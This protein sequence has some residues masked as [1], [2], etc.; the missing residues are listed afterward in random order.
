MI[1]AIKLQV[2]FRLYMHILVMTRIVP[3]HSLGGMQKQTMDLC[4]GFVNAGHKVTLITTGRKDGVTQESDNGIDI[5]YLAKSKPG[6]YSRK[7]NSL[8]KK[9]VAKLHNESPIDVI[10]SQSMGANGVL[11][12]ANR[13]SVPIVSTWHGTS[14][15]EISTFFSSASWSPRY[16]HWLLIMPSRMLR[17]YFLLD[18]PVR[19]ASQ[20]IT[21]VSPTLEPNMKLLAKNKVT[22]ISNGIE[23][24][25][26]TEK[27]TNLPIQV[28]SIG[29]IEKEKGIHHGIN[30]IAKLPSELQQQV[31]LNIVGTGPYLENL[32][33]LVTH[34]KLSKTVTFHGR[35]ADDELFKIYQQCRIHLMPT[36]RQEGLPLTILEGMAFS[37]ATIASDIGGIPGVITDKVDGLLV[38]PGN[39]EDLSNA[40]TLLL[41]STD[42]LN[43]LANKARSTIEQRYSRE[44]MVNETLEVFNLV[45][46]K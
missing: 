26:L 42:Q 40:L 22:T 32:Q 46:R 20:H 31:H 43:D 23:I 10:H 2:P 13:N 16:W 25:P 45:V 30:A 34:H 3:R 36:T 4:Y 1:E 19:K 17:Q 37:L 18:L 6:Y 24:P 27:S 8:C 21:L 44:R 28:I 35:L 12:W 41:K 38:K 33:S 11:K 9:A 39:V 5:R 14:L 29:R 7:W 15:T